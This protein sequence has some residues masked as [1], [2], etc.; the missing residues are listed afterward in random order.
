MTPAGGQYPRGEGAPAQ[1]AGTHS[2]PSS[3]FW[4]RLEHRYTLKIHQTDMISHSMGMAPGG[5]EIA[6]QWS[7]LV[8]RWEAT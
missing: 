1:V 2:P 3:G 4:F 6:P 8:L 5:S 7:S